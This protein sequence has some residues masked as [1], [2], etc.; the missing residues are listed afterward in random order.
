MSG[1]IEGF[2]SDIPTSLPFA[3]ECKNT[4][5]QR[6][7]QEWE[8]C[9]GQVSFNRKPVLVMSGNH[10]AILVAMDVH[11]WIDLLKELKDYKRRA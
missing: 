11:D 2:E 10:W 5:K 7:W 6:I 8:Q 9:R 3:F 1:A 4:E